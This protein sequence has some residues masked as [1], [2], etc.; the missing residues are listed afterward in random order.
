[1]R[2][3]EGRRAWL[4]L[5]SLGIAQPADIVQVMIYLRTSSSRFSRARRMGEQHA[6]AADE[7]TLSSLDGLP[8]KEPEQYVEHCPLESG[9]ILGPISPM[10]VV[11]EIVPGRTEPDC[12]VAVPARII[13]S[14]KR[15]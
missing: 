5:L 14:A 9:I 7:K 11:I 1:M 13:G 2:A 8:S 4:D 15:G 3:A 12:Y 6:Q 10:T